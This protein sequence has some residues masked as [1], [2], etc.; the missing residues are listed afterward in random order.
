MIDQKNPHWYFKYQPEPQSIKEIL[1]A[2][3]LNRGLTTK[4]GIADFLKPSD[5]YNIPLSTV[6]IDTKTVQSTIRRIKT[7]ATNKE[8]VIIYG[9]YD[10]DG[11]TGTAILWETLNKLGL[12]TMPFIPQRDKHGYGLSKKGIDEILKLFNS[13]TRKLLITVDNGIVAFEGA[14]YCR[15]LGIDLIIT[16]HHQKKSHSKKTNFK[17]PD[18]HAVVWSDKVAGCGVAWFLAREIYKKLKNKNLSG[19]KQSNSLELAAIGTTADMMPLFENNRSLVYFGLKE[20]NRTTR[21][22]IKALIDTASLQNKKIGTYEVNFVLAPRINAMGRLDSALDSLRLLCTKDLERAQSLATKLGLV[23]QERQDATRQN[24]S[25]AKDIIKQ[26]N[27]WEKKLLFIVDKSFNPGVIGLVAGRLAEKFS[28]PTVVVALGKEIA[29]GSARS[30]RNFNL[31]NFLRTFDE[32][33]VDL[34]G[35]PMAAGFNIDL[36]KVNKLGASLV[37][38]AGRV[39]K[40]EW[41]I[42]TTNIDCRIS[43]NHVNWSLWQEIEKMKPF[44]L[45]NTRPVFASQSVSL[46]DFRTVGNEG[47]HLKARFR[48]SKSEP[49]TYEA[50]G[51]GLGNLA[52][53]LSVTKPVD[54]AYS[55]D[56]NEWN[57]RKTLQ[58][59]LRDI[60]PSK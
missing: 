53:K 19:F 45:G 46:V 51:F 17:L 33:F 24:L 35:H 20:L 27:L 47:R 56:K 36:K 42:P 38:E 8:L 5:P 25:T 11:I 7:A 15:K 58:L 44:G 4:R 39:I 43:L 34:G 2:L 26:N 41:L 29:K 12:K 54:I 13:K 52:E 18:C 31:I 60:K 6:G 3:M 23:N 49:K 9:D 59:L 1:H 55:V 30:V 16:D 28:I 21:I 32:M 40:D 22:G 48:I 37:K 14:E 10:A 57:G 50:I